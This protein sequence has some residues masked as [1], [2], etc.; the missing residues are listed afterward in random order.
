MIQS[1]EFLYLIKN[2]R[3]LLFLPQELELEPGKDVITWLARHYRYRLVGI[4]ESLTSRSSDGKQENR[5]QNPP[6]KALNFARFLPEALLESGEPARLL[7]NH[8]L[9]ANLLTTPLVTH[10]KLAPVVEA[11][12]AVV[13]ACHAENEP[14]DRNRKF[15]IRVGDY[16]MTDFLTTLVPESLRVLTDHDGGESIREVLRY[17]K[18]TAAKDGRTRFW[19]L[20]EEGKVGASSEHFWAFYLDP[21]RVL[22]NSEGQQGHPAAELLKMLQNHTQLLNLT[23]LIAL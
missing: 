18:E 11:S 12:G 3:C 4:E 15:N 16:A 14:D 22:L 9:V 19:R 13:W 2:L 7:L 23:V 21:W 17:R 20:L 10:R 8:A 1:H 6:F 5:L